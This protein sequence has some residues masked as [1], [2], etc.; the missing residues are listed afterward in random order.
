MEPYSDSKPLTRW[1][2]FSGPINEKDI[3]FQLSWLKNNGFGGVEIAWVYPLPESP[4]GPAWLS[5]ELSDKIRHT[6]ERARSLGLA[7]DFTFG[8]LWPFGGSMVSEEDA[9]KDF[10]GTS[11]QRIRK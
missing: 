2:W 8:T 10:Y 7:C 9:S 1:W 11:K 3:D 4:E 5:R 6:K